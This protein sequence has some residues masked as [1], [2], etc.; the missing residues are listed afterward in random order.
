M[1]FFF[2]AA[3]ATHHEV[4]MSGIPYPLEFGREPLVLLCQLV[5]QFG[6]FLF[7]LLAALDD[8]AQPRARTMQVRLQLVHLVIVLDLDRVELLA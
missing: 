6:L 1:I 3:A 7:V 4:C 8:G 2:S 5:D